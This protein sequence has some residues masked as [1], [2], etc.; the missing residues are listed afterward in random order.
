MWNPRWVDI[1]DSA[2]SQQGELGSTSQLCVTRISTLL[3]IVEDTTQGLIVN[4]GD[5]IW[6][7]ASHSIQ[8][9]ERGPRLFEIAGMASIA[10]TA[11]A[12][13]LMGATIS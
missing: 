5:V 9:E 10:F 13:A 7:S 8:V 12:A 1:L 2:S 4:H 3:V 6:G 11:A